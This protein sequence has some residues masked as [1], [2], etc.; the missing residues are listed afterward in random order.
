[1]KK[2]NLFSKRAVMEKILPVIENVCAK[3]GLIPIEVNL[4]K[5]SGRWFLRIFIFSHDHPITHKD[6]E[7][8][9]RFLGDYLDELIPVKYYVE[10]SSPGA[11]R[12]IKSSL[13]YTIFE[14]KKVRVKLNQPIID[15]N[16]IL[17]GTIVDYQRNI[18]LKIK[19]TDEE[20]EVI[21]KEENIQSANLCLEELINRRTK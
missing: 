4:I 11:E 17:Y 19:L 10:I 21:I 1:M 15:E 3:N 16:K 13:E 12:K 9:T 18:G 8:V 6:C 20:K 14:G 5:E 7:A 2:E